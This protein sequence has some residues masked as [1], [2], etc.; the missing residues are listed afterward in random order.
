[1]QLTKILATAGFALLGINLLKANTKK[2][3]PRAVMLYL[4]HY[5]PQQGE[6]IAMFDDFACVN[7]EEPRENLTNIIQL[8]VPHGKDFVRLSGS[9]GLVKLHL[10]FRAF[11]PKF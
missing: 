6:G 4:R 8:Q 7:W 9:P 10:T 3:N 11:Q 1:M 5:P 2:D